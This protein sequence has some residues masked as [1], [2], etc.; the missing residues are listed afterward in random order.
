MSLNQYHHQQQQQPSHVHPQI[1]QTCTG[2]AVQIPKLHSRVYYFPQGH[3]EHASSS[4]SNAYIH[5]LDLQRFRPFTICIIS[6]VDLLADPHT[7]EVFAKLLLTPVTNNSC[8]QDPHEVPNCS[9]D[10]DVCDEVIDSFTRIL[11]LTNVSKHAFYI[12]RFCAENMFPPLG[13]EVSQHLLVTDVHGE[14]WKFHHVC[15]GFAK[16]NVFYTSEWA[17]FVE[18]KKLDVGDAVVFMK[19]STG[20]LFV[21]IRRKD[22]AEQKK[23]ELEKAVMEAVKLAEENKPFEIVYYPRGDDWCDFVVDGNIVDE[24]MKIQ[25]NPRMRVKMKTDKSSRIPYQGTIT[26]VSRTSNLWRMLQV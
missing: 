2:A 7:D 25:W 14:V 16:R 3:L 9:N 4:S 23:D 24:S 26:T 13:M 17:S 10:D 18:R 19:N 5:S 21:G 11:A 15:H 8:V 6:A 12:P 20:K 22:A 1:W